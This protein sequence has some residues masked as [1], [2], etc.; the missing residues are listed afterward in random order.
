MTKL[1][2]MDWIE[3]FLKDD[4]WKYRQLEGKMILKMGLNLKC[5]MKST[6]LFIDV[7]DD[8]YLV[9]AISPLKGDPESLGEILRY[10]SLVN[11]GMKNGN[12]ELDVED[13]EIRYK[14]YVNLDGA[15]EIP[16]QVLKDSIYIPV[17]MMDKYGNGIAALSM[18]FSD[19][20][21]EYQNARS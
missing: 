8:E 1:Q 20:D 5:K 7:K 2:I 12:F 19:A 15:T 14:T 9:Y 4:D 11:Y 17:M 3:G 21:T 16:T 18:G 10:I 6:D 13:G